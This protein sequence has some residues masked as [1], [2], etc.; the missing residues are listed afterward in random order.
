MAVHDFREIVCPECGKELPWLQETLLCVKRR[1]TTRGEL[2]RAEWSRV[3]GLAYD[4]I[5]C[6]PGHDLRVWSQQLLCYGQTACPHCNSSL[7]VSIQVTGEHDG[8]RIP[9]LWAPSKAKGRR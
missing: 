6:G 2:G 5:P 3:A 4:S 1:A 9:D 7:D 8:K